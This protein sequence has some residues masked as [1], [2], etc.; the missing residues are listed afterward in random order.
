MLSYMACYYSPDSHVF[1]HV[2]LADSVVACVNGSGMLVHVGL[3][4]NVFG[5]LV[6]CV[7]AVG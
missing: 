4:G 1:F 7:E 5:G 2:I 3:G 6:V